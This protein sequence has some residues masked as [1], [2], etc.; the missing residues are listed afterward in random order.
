MFQPAAGERAPGAAVV[1]GYRLLAVAPK[2][3]VRMVGRFAW[4]AILTRS[5]SVLD[6]VMRPSAEISVTPPQL[7]VAEAGREGN[8]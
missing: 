7:R 3:L 1:T 5:S 6:T 4:Y 2:S 8:G